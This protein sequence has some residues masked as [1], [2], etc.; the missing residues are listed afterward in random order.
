MSLHSY[1]RCWLHL[2]WGTLRREKL[3]HFKARIQVA[4]YCKKYAEEKNIYLKIVYVNPDHIH[5]LIDLPTKY[6]IEEVTQ[7]FKGSSSHWINQNSIIDVK[8][9]WGRGY[10]AFSVSESD[11]DRVARY[12]ADQEEHHRIKSFLDEYREFIT[13][14][15][16]EVSGSVD[17]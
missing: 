12:I 7:L 14:Y 16:L 6:S 1:S 11:V 8:F 4:G 3:L 5:L 15:G 13:A 9:A 2:I 10:G 17:D